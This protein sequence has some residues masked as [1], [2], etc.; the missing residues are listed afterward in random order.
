MY[1]LDFLFLF[2]SKIYFKL[3]EY[4]KVIKENGSNQLLALI[5]TRFELF[6]DAFLTSN[7]SRC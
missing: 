4:L 3:N 2:I 5:L 7:F 6:P 1:S